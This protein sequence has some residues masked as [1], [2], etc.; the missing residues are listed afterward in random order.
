M[1]NR[2]AHHRCQVQQQQFADRNPRWRDD[3]RMVCADALLKMIRDRLF[4]MPWSDDTIGQ[5]ERLATETTLQVFEPYRG[6]LGDGV[7]GEL[8]LLVGSEA[9]RLA[10]IAR[11]GPESARETLQ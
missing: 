2:R 4:P 9:K 10:L 11:D 1:S 8:V 5:I 7:F 3:V 6:Q